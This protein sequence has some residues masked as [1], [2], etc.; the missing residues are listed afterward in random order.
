MLS[1][2]RPVGVDVERISSV[3]AGDL[4]L[5]LTEREHAWA[6]PDPLRCLALWTR[7]EAIAKAAGTAGLRAMPGIEVIDEPVLVD[8]VEWHTAA[9]DAGPGYVAHVAL[10]GAPPRPSVERLTVAGLV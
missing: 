1:A 9:V 2:C 8:G 7:K 5:Y 3:T 10:A 4:R 6:G